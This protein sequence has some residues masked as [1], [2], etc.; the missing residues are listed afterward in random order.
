MRTI[1]DK[2]PL[3]QTLAQHNIFAQKKMAGKSKFGI[4]E[5]PVCCVW[6]LFRF[7]LFQSH[8]PFDVLFTQSGGF[9]IM[10]I[11]MG[12]KGWT[13]TMCYQMLILMMTC[14]NWRLIPRTSVRFLWLKGRTCQPCL[15]KKRYLVAIHGTGIFAYTWPYIWLIVMVNPAKLYIYGMGY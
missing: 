13:K 2:A 4:S 10:P 7:V 8:G 9:R 1:I 12:K 5:S 3:P 11:I 14:H 15:P 6:L